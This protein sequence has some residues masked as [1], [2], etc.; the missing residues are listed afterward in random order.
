METSRFS[1]CAG[2]TSAEGLSIA[3]QAFLRHGNVSLAG[4]KL[5]GDGAFAGRDLIRCSGKD[6]SASIAPGAWP[7]VNQPIGCSHGIEIMLDDDDCIAQIAQAG[8]GGE[9]FFI[10]ALM[11]ADAGFVKNIQHPHQSAADLAGQTDALRFPAGKG[12]LSRSG[13]EL[14]PLRQESESR[15]DSRRVPLQWLVPVREVQLSMKVQASSIFSGR[16][17]RYSVRDGDR[18]LS[19]LSRFPCIW[20]DLKAHVL[21]QA[22]A[23]LFVLGFPWRRSRFGICLQKLSPRLHFPRI[24]ISK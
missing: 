16:N 17:H 8:Q 22:S 15:L 6:Q 1:G 10:V 3:F 12:A 13:Q 20:A 21:L 14:S 9:Q 4:E 2:G 19:A 24:Q 23:K 11:Q 5:P 18:K 7:Q